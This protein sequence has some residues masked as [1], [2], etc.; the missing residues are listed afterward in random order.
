MNKT[1]TFL[2]ILTVIVGIAGFYWNWRE[3]IY[4]KEILRLEILGPSEITLGQE[5]EYIVKYKNNGNFRLDNP[6]LVFEPPEHSLKDEEI[7]TRQILD[8]EKLGGAIY[9]GEE[10]SF[11][12][13]MRL[14]G[15]E[16]EVK[17]ARAF[18]TYKLKDLKAQ[19][20]SSSSFTT[21]IKSV[22]LTFDFDLPSRVGA[23]KE[24]T[25]RLNYFSNIDY[26]L[27]DLRCQI[28]YPFGFE[29]NKSN[30][31]SIEKTEWE[32]PVLNKSKGGRIEITG[33]ISGEIGTAKIFKARL[34]MWK[35]GEFILLKEVTKGVEIIEPSLYLRQEINSNP[36]YVA[37]PGDWLHYEI[38]FKNIGNDDLNNLFM[39]SKLDGEAFDFQTIKSDYGNYQTGDNSIVFDWRRVPKLQYLAP[40]E[41]GRVDFW[42]KLKDDLGSIKNPIL[43]NK[44]FI[45]QVKEEFVTKIS[46]KIELVQ[47][48][49]FQ[50]E[51]F[52]N[53]GPLPPE[54][55]KTT[56]YTIMWQVK[57]YYSDVKNVKVKAVLPEGVELT[58]EIFP[59]E[60]LSRFT[61]DSQSRE[62][63]WSVGDL[64]RGIGVT[65][66]GLTLAFQIAFTPSES[67][68]FQI[69]EI[70]NQAN[71][72]GEDSWTEMTIQS[73]ASGINTF[74]PDDPTVTDEMGLVK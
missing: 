5:V 45:G 2:I 37:L 39:V 15:K 64:E 46:S 53:S 55:G 56:T 54:V 30:P 38:Y 40:L 3:N 52:G 31:K 14:L 25:F 22:H 51:V 70:I 24:F 74:L 11:P 65:K 27:T 59:E 68:R 12:F 6:V 42:I 60:E 71:I 4:S 63:V 32:I 16:G 34:G 66:Q 33:K 9:P 50:D 57:N 7:F 19:Y 69:P 43:K 62:I 41:E 26:P 61:F 17:I 35:K 28:D 72:M 58:G 13:K 49:Y 20:E 1:F 8:S 10:R 18:L 44:I 67:Q 21:Q 48:G 36:Q 47:K 23:D 29:F 73:S